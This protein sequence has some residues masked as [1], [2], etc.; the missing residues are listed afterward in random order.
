MRYKNAAILILF[1]KY[2]NMGKIIKA[3]L[4]KAFIIFIFCT[5]NFRFPSY[6]PIQKVRSLIQ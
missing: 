1:H 2:R 3:L 5:P 4:D 6:F